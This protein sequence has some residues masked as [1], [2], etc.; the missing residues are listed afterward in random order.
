MSAWT[1]LV[2]PPVLGSSVHLQSGQ[3]VVCQHGPTWSFL[4]SWGLLFTSS[5]VSQWCVSMDQPGPSSSILDQPGLL[6]TS[7]QVSQ[8]CVS[9]DQP[10]PSSCLGVFCSPPVRSASGVSAWT[11]LVLPPVLGSSVHPQSGQSVGQWGRGRGGCSWCQWWCGL[12][13]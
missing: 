3:P 12:Q 4:L 7:S 9:M 2:L 11:N 1:N 6:F 8:W 13:C 5:Q 10:G